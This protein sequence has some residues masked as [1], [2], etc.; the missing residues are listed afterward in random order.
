MP[1]IN[2]NDAVHESHLDA[3]L[4]E[5]CEQHLV[6]AEVSP[7]AANHAQD[8]INAASCDIYSD[9]GNEILE[10]LKESPDLTQMFFKWL[11]VGT[12]LCERQRNFIAALEIQLA[13][14]FDDK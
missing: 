10:A 12:P 13:K 11:N 4:Y 9:S 8:A 3:D 7:E 2:N 1:D 6:D 14:D 5:G